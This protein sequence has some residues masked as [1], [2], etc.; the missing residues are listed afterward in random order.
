VGVGWFE[1]FPLLLG[2]IEKKKS[3]QYV[4]IDVG[5]QI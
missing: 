3:S 1:P 4:G 5:I 2:Y